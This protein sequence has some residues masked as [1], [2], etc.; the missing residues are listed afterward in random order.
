MLIITRAVLSPPRLWEWQG[1]KMNMR[2]STFISRY[3]DPG[4][5]KTITLNNQNN[6]S[7]ELSAFYMRSPNK[8]S[9]LK[10]WNM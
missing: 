9:E 5:L 7:T 3:L 4:V 2:S 10:Y 8:L 6:I 1:E